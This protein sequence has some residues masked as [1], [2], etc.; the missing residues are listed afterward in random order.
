MSSRIAVA[1]STPSNSTR[2]TEAVMGISIFINADRSSTLVTV[3]TPSTTHA[4]YAIYASSEAPRAIASPQD[5]LRPSGLKQVVA[6]SP[7]PAMP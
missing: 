4:C 6:R 1:G 2:P 5:R 7:T 3:G